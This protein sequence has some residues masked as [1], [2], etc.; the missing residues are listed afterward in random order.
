MNTIRT[1]RNELDSFGYE[2]PSPFTVAFDRTFERLWEDATRSN[3]DSNYPA[4]NVKKQDQ[5]KFVIEMALA[6]FSRADLDIEISDGTL[7]VNSTNKP[8]ENEQE[9]TVLYKGIAKREF[10]R[11]FNL[12]DDIVVKDASIKDG[13]LSINLEKVI[14]EGRRPRKISIN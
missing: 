8:S 6:G 7:S 9:S 14:P 13:M 3:S 12:A 2:L 11:R 1:F 4:F 5:D 10:T